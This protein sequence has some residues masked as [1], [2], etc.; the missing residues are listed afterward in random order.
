M[1]FKL[2]PF[3]SFSMVSYLSSIVNMSI[4]RRFWDIGRKSWF[5]HTPL[6]ST[7]RLGGGVPSE[8]CH[9]VC[10]RKTRMAWLPDGELTI[11]LTVLTKYRRVT[12]GWTD[13][14]TSCHGIVRA[15]AE[16][17]RNT[18]VCIRA[19]GNTMIRIAGR[20]GVAHSC[21]YKSRS[22]MHPFSLLCSRVWQPRSS[23]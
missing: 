8:Y 2:V 18:V 6:H 16:I 11:R 5:F 20:A 14:Q 4:L 7:P 12:N 9:L 10:Y 17:L 15:Y 21:L 23:V 1:S 3:E 19:R 22:T 13:G